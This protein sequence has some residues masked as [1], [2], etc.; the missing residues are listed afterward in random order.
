MSGR[1][2]TEEPQQVAQEIEQSSPVE[3]SP[4][5]QE[6]QQAGPVEPGH[7]APREEG[8]ERVVDPWREIQRDKDFREGRS[9]VEF[10]PIQPAPENPPPPTPGID[11]DPVV[12]PEPLAE[13]EPITEAASPPE[14]GTEEIN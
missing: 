10:R 9:G 2:V 3:Q 12:Q 11:P 6:V 8:R 4:Q 5:Q 1:E 14:L 13:P 7:R